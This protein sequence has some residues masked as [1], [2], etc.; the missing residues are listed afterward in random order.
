MRR[1]LSFLII[2]FRKLKEVGSIF[3]RRKSLRSEQ[4]ID[5]LGGI[6]IGQGFIIDSFK[7][8]N[9]QQYVSQINAL[10]DYKKTINKELINI[11]DV[12][13]NIG[14]TTIAFAKNDGVRVFSFEPYPDSFNYLKSNVHSNKLNN[15]NL[16]P[17][18]LYSRNE[19]KNIGAPRGISFFKYFDLE[20]LGMKSIYHVND[21]S[22]LFAEFKKADDCK[23]LNQ[24]K[25]IDIV[26]IDVEGAEYDVLK[27]FEKLLRK[28]KPLLKIEFS[29][30]S[31]ANS[32]HSSNKLLSLISNIGY[33]SIFEN[34]DEFI[35]SKN[36]RQL[37][38][39]EY[40]KKNLDLIFIAE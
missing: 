1:L 32:G 31:F 30:F 21:K 36:K 13:A 8:L 18:G 39:Y 15:V 34:T 16:F 29:P 25:S 38:S 37:C 24:L 6:L 10:I 33:C 19:T 20:N 17:F 14:Q 23:E 40:P 22:A 26:K 3:L 4:K 2:Y 5:F 12:G 27:G 28:H 7:D 35:H 11:I 9:E